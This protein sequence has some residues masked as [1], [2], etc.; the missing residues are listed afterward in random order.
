MA[1]DG[2]IYYYSGRKLHRKNGPAIIWPDGSKQ[3]YVN[4]MLHRED[5]PAIISSLGFNYYYIHG[6]CHREDGPAV[7]GADGLV[8]V[9]CLNGKKYSKEEFELRAS[10]FLFNI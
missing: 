4:G 9:Y 2:A 5:G 3:Y 10:K 6:I 1:P 8:I 7:V